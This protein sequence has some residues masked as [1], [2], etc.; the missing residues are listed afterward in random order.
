MINSSAPLT[1]W[2]AITQGRRAFLMMQTFIRK[3]ENLWIKPLLGS[4]LYDDVKAGIMAKN[5]SEDLQTLLDSYLIPVLV[6]RTLMEALP[7]ISFQIST[8]GIRVLSD[9]DGVKQRLA[10]DP[11]SVGAMVINYKASADQLTFEAKRFLE[12]NPEKYPS[13]AYPISETGATRAPTEF[14]N[15]NKP[16]FLFM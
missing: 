10:A 12:A 16:S 7:K 8:A 6:D 2:A 9:N 15:K 14:D 13:Y 4:V 3:A 5:L 11:Q 1:H